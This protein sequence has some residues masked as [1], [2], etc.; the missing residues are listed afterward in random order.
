MNT[1]NLKKYTLLNKIGSGTF[2]EVYKIQDKK[3]SK[4][5]A[6]KISTQSFEE[7]PESFIRN[8]EREVSII[9]KV[10]HPSIIKFIGSTMKNFQNEDKPIIVTDYLPNESLE[11]VLQ[12]SQNSRSPDQWDDTA[13]LILIYGVASA[14]TFLHAHGIIHRDLKPANILLDKNFYPVIADFGLSK[15]EDSTAS[16]TGVKG[17]PLYI[18]PEIWEENEY[19]KKSDVYAYAFILYEILTDTRPYQDITMYKISQ[20]ACNGERPDTTYVPEPYK[21]LIEN[22]WEKEPFDRPDFDQIAS[23]LKTNEEFITEQVD[24]ETFYAYVSYIDES[25]QSFDDTPQTA[26]TVTT[27]TTVEFPT[28]LYDQ[29]TPKMK[30]IVDEANDD[31]EKSY[32]LGS[33]LVSGNK[34]FPKDVTLGVEY[35]KRS[36]EGGNLNA[37][38]LYNRMLIIG[39]K[40]EK[41]LEEAKENLHKFDHLHNADVTFLQAMISHS[42]KDYDTAVKLLKKS[43]EGQNGE[44]MFVYGRMLYIGEGVEKNRNEAM[45][46]FKQAKENGCDKSDKFLEEQNDQL[47]ENSPSSDDI[48]VVFLIDGSNPNKFFYES[49]KQTFSRFAKKCTKD[50]PQKKFRFGAVI[51]VDFIV[52]IKMQRKCRKR[53]FVLSLTDKIDEVQSFFDEHY[54]VG[55]GIRY[56]NDMAIC[57]N[58]LLDEMNW[59]EDSQKVAIQLCQVPGH[60]IG[61]TTKKEWHKKYFNIPKFNEENSFADNLRIYNEIQI[62]QRNWMQATVAKLAENGI[63]LFCLNG[64][65]VTMYF[66]KRIISWY[67]K[68]HGSKFVIKNLFGFTSMKKDD[69]TDMKSLNKNM[70]EFLLNVTK[71]I[72]D[73]DDDEFVNNCEQ[74]FKKDLDAFFKENNESYTEKDSD[75]SDYESNYES[76]DDDE[77]NERQ[78]GSK[79]VKPT[80]S[81]PVINR[82]ND[83]KSTKPSRPK[84]TGSNSSANSRKVDDDDNESDDDFDS[85]NEDDD[86]KPSKNKKVKS[87]KSSSTINRP[88]NRSGDKKT[89][90]PNRLRFSGSKSTNSHKGDDDDDTND[91]DD[92]KP[93]RNSNRRRRAPKGNLFD[94]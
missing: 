24:S 25:P 76:D 77:N 12:L 13:K 75:E 72:C 31:S 38:L 93:N 2:G 90:K 85:N 29:L 6:A 18:A 34:G 66:L 5:Y 21:S 80:N 79:K 45:K 94:F 78:S 82:P 32:I 22:C 73:N 26:E 4:I 15:K 63:M 71:S 56:A 58:C 59:K 51:Y 55:G 53:P 40:I 11:S 8:F 33:Y 43:I 7:L 37:V 28:D 49:I 47:V 70:S 64:N 92:E 27:A 68:R 3:T 36:I 17:T 50:Y 39:K 30:K 67:Y 62:K 10:H 60:G 61:L 83:K 9:S 81:S 52:L 84:L 48:D 41:N 14:M 88:S 46:F 87:A 69:S 16:T 42:E 65:E 89:A 23:E 35:L 54:T 44:A 20:K 74:Q 1:L 91:D 57:Y 19:S 86:I